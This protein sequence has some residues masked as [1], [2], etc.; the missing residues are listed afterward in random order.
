MKKLEYIDELMTLVEGELPAVRS[1]KQPERLSQIKRT[2]RDYYQERKEFYGTGYPDF[3]DKDLC[4]LFSDNPK[5]KA[6]NNKPPIA[7]DPCQLI[8]KIKIGAIKKKI[9]PIKEYKS[10]FVNFFKILKEKNN[11][12]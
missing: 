10:E 6:H 3:Y 1:R 2:L 5:Y 4:R 7:A 12:K 11:C 8:L 9:D